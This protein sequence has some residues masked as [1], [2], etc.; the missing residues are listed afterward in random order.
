MKANRTCDELG[1]CQVE[2]AAVFAPQRL[3]TVRRCPR[4]THQATASAHPFAP[5]VI[6]G[7]PPRREHWA[8]SLMEA[9]LD[10]ILIAG[11]CAMVAML[12]GIVVGRLNG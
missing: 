12:L 10:V 5:G 11:G 2:A 4:C 7:P 3:Q 6:E 9:A 8:Y 1:M